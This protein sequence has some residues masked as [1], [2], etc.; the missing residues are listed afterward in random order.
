MWAG[1]G[2][3]IEAKRFWNL[4]HPADGLL[5]NKSR[6]ETRLKFIQFQAGFFVSGAIAKA[7]IAEFSANNPASNS[8]ILRTVLHR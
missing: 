2:D 5:A 4:R 8:A 3:C 7:I 6:P 1:N